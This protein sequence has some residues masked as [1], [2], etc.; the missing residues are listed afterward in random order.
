MTVD[1]NAELVA[2]VEPASLR[3]V[4]RPTGNAGSPDR[5]DV[6]ITMSR[7]DVP[8]GIP[9][10][11]IPI[12]IA[13]VPGCDIAAEAVHAEDTQGTLVLRSID[14][15]ADLSGFHHSRRYAF[16]RETRGEVRIRYTA[17]ATPASEPR[18]SGPPFD[19]ICQDGGLSAAGATFLILPTDDLSWHIRLEWDL[20]ALLPSMT[21]VSSLG[22]GVVE[23]VGALDRVK[24]CF[25]MAGELEH[26]DQQGAIADGLKAYWLGMPRFDVVA[27]M[28]WLA[29]VY[30]QLA[31]ILPRAGAQPFRVMGR[32][33]SLP[34]C[35]GAAMPDS[36]MIG[37]GQ[38]PQRE[39]SVKFLLAHELAHPLAG[40]MDGKG[41][42]CA[43]YA[44]GLA[45]FYKLMVPLREGLV[46]DD[47][48]LAELSQSTRGYYMNPNIDLANADIEAMFWSNSQVRK[49]PYER[50]LL[51]FLELDWQLRRASNGVRTLETLIN[52]MNENRRAGQVS[53][54]AFWRAL[55]DESL[56]K[57]GLQAIDDVLTGVR[58][59]PPSGVFGSGF[60]RRTLTMREYV[61]G[62][63]EKSF[64][65]GRIE[66]LI[67]GSAASLAG[68]REGDRIITHDYSNRDREL[69]PQ[70]L[71]LSVERDSE[72]L[73]IRYV[74]AGAIVQG[75][76]WVKVGA[77]VEKSVTEAGA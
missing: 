42:E 9:A 52:R 40:S 72:S 5:I 41:N 60:E 49:L 29:D 13:S 3:I 30:A 70:P 57:A 22:D 48:F 38:A 59:V 69:E 1:R 47:E 12:R 20:S 55:V 65:A 77:P 53:D 35:G 67:E 39:A 6:D 4:L 43:W 37:Y 26:A 25:Y 62:F 46:D 68:L 63:A 33:G 56:G 17:N 11:A 16:N 21:S 74:P 64:H 23:I 61:L 10:L 24:Y 66:E 7:L 31:T 18:R 54:I 50:G 32:L 27:V 2:L 8:S 58:L 51:Y 44:E 36:F 73:L 34:V 76:E 15:A 19:L 45:E 71:T 75:F 28:T 14:D